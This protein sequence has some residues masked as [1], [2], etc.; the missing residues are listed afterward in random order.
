MDWPG[1]Q[2]IDRRR[3]ELDEPIRSLGD[4]QVDIRVMTNVTAHVNVA[5]QPEE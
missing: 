2:E 4:H 3:I 1:G 5:V